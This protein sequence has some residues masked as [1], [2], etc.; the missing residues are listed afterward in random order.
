MHNIFTFWMMS[1]LVARQP[2]GGSDAVVRKQSASG[3]S[4]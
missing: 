3:D 1:L 2:L 4:V